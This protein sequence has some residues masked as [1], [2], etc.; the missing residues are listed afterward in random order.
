MTATLILYTT[1]ACHLCREAE[2][3]LQQLSESI[4]VTV[5]AIDISADEELVSRYGIRIPVVKNK[6]T[7]IEIGWPFGL[8]ELANLI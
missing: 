7:D 5:E 1:E 3:L 6:L 4:E 2:Q 8:A